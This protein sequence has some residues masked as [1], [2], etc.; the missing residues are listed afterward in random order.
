MM[1]SHGQTSRILGQELTLR[2]LEYLVLV[3]K[4][5]EIIGINNR[6]NVSTARVRP[7]WNPPG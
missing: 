6:K 2:G 4:N 5:R 7:P 1:P 3:N